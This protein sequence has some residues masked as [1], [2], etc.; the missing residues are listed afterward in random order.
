[1][2]NFLLLMA[3]E[4]KDETIPTQLIEDDSKQHVST[5]LDSRGVVIERPLPLLFQ[6]HQA[7]DHSTN[8]VFIIITLNNHY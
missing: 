3:V 2:D 1:M 7:R 4:V 6:L 5:E 8:S